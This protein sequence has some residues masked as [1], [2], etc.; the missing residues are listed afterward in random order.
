MKFG[1]IF[2]LEVPRPWTPES[3]RSVFHE[4]V[5]QVVEA[6][7]VGFDYVWLVEHHFLEEF[8]HSTAPE[9]YLGYLAARTATIRLGHG[10]VLLEGKVNHPVRVAERIATLDILS[11]GRVEFGTGRGGNPWQI[12]P[13]GSDLASAREEWEEAVEIIPRMWRDEWFHHSGR[14]FEIPERNVLPK[15]V[16]RP[17][18]P[19][20]MACNQPES[21]EIAGRKGIGAL[22]FTIGAPGELEERIASYRRAVAAAP[23][24]VGSF[25]NDQ[26]AAFTIAHCDESDRVA[27]EIAGPQA[28][29]YFETI[30]KIYAPVWQSRSI[31]DVPPSYRW[32]ALHVTQSERIRG[33]DEKVRNDYNRL[34]DSGAMCI[35]DPAACI[36][37]VDTYRS[38]GADQVCAMFQ[39][40]RVPHDQILK[41][42]RLFGEKVIPVFR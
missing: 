11:N 31:E 16:Q 20:W 39:V 6:E 9:V 19:I 1:L 26:V 8:A 42:I 36:R 37:T 22:C 25:K 21:F 7:R 12:E 38:Y 2:E 10:V 23:E 34:I 17:H 32:H 4:A 15:P 28:M 27:R 35:G 33:S 24:Q 3:E 41:S 14:H 30:K 5:D 18:P 29:W 13:F 40:G